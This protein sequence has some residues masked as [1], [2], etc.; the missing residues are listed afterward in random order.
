MLFFDI[1][2][3]HSSFFENYIFSN[4]LVFLDLYN[5]NYFYYYS[6]YNK[7]MLLNL[8][9]VFDEIRYTSN[10]V[11]GIYLLGIPEINDINYNY[12]NLFTYGY[13]FN[14]VNK[15]VYLNSNKLWTDFVYYFFENYKEFNFRTGGKGG[16]SFNRKDIVHAGYYSNLYSKFYNFN[17]ADFDKSVFLEDKALT[18][19]FGKIKIKHRF[20]RTR[21]FNQMSSFWKDF[22]N[23]LK[24]F[25]YYNKNDSFLKYNKLS[26]N[27]LYTKGYFSYK[28]YKF[29]EKSKFILL[30]SYLF[31][32]L[33]INKQKIVPDL[34]KY[35]S[36]QEFISLKY[37]NVGVN[38]A[39]NMKYH[40]LK[41]DQNFFFSKD[42]RDALLYK[43]GLNDNIWFVYDT[44]N[45][46]KYH[47]NQIWYI[48]DSYRKVLN[49]YE[50][51]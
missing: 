48:N 30:N 18:D 32:S 45:F 4:N 6:F 37:R 33:F 34:L 35:F 10:G 14:L 42:I 28:D 13:N 41:Y 15:F 26:E 31:D 44:L 12:N 38:I 49:Y 39:S 20:F 51:K 25:L 9:C 23:N 40:F 46:D 24:L 16:V 7:D 11:I 29:E 47:E 17:G 36:H 2:Y 3:L 50:I 27:F 21:V 43:H 1:N 8:S 22:Q 5:M 19:Y